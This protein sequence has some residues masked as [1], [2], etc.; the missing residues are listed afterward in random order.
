MK[1]CGSI[2]EK[3]RRGR[4]RN[5]KIRYELRQFHT[6]RISKNKTFTMMWACG[7][8]ARGYEA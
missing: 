2:C 6:E 3:T 4:L 1:C 5:G 7:K 8:D